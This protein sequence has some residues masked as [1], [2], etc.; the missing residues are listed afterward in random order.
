VPDGVAFVAGDER[1][2]DSFLSDLDG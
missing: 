1:D 2:V